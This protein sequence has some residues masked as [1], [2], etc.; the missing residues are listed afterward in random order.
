MTRHRDT[1]V[2]RAARV[3]RVT[4]LAL[5]ALT[6]AV[7]TAVGAAAAPAAPA[8]GAGT[9]NVDDVAKRYGALQ[10]RDLPAGYELD[11]VRRETGAIAGYF[12]VQGDC[13]RI[14]T[15]V[16]FFDGDPTIVE[17]SFEETTSTGRL[18]GQGTQTVYDFD[19]DDDAAEELYRRFAPN[20]DELV[21]CGL[22]TDAVGNIGT[23]AD[24]A[25]GKIG[26]QRTAISFD[27]RA[28]RFTRLGLARDDDTVVYL[29]LY[30]DTATDAEFATLLKQA[31]RRAR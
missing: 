12:E 28:D 18:G 10:T 22:M 27:P 7:A 11:S 1:R 2:A 8:A 26:D 15:A 20:F 6:A 5:V 25:I 16:K 19:G 9:E 14:N 31:V 21:A 29:V 17:A 24:L 3:S 13:A 30:D 4:R 23:Y